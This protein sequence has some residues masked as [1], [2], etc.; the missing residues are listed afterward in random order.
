MAGVVLSEAW[1]CES[2]DETRALA[3]RIARHLGPSSFLALEGE[4]GAGKTTFVQGLCAALE[5]TEP[6]ASPTFVLL[7]VYRGHWPV[8]HFDAYRLEGPQDLG[9][10]GADEYFWGDGITVLEWADRVTAALPSDRLDIRLRVVAE[11]RRR[12][13]VSAQGARHAEILRG[14]RE[15][16]IA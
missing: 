12:V 16:E 15:E 5:V 3:G 2:E 9:D 14:L 6:V 11:G 4:L 8:Y 7:R 10:L 1:N 13:E